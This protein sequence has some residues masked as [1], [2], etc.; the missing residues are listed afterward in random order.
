MKPEE[1]RPAPV[2]Q[3]CGLAVVVGAA[4]GLGAALLAQ[5]QAEGSYARVLALGRSSELPIN[6]ADEGSIAAAAQSVGGLCAESGLE[7][8][9]LLVASG[10]LHG[11]AGQPERSWSQLDASYLEHVFLVN[12]FGPALMIKHFF[13]LLPK[14]GHCVAGFVSARVGSIADNALGGWYGYRASKAALNQLVKTASIELTRR[15][16]DSVCVALHPGT[17]DT[18]LSQPFARAGLQIRPPQQAAEEL[19]GVITG[20]TPADTGALLDYRGQTL[21]F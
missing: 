7:L 16:R 8:R 5:L 14:R 20:L 1:S 2:S 4:G 9:M 18:A 10:F 12:T 21:P 19:L 15:N 17:V 3:R 6:Y 13:P 11:E